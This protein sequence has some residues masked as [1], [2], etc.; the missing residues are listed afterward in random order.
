MLQTGTGDDL[1]A[2]RR[3]RDVGRILS[4]LLDPALENAHIE[5]CAVTAYI[6]RPLHHPRMFVVELTSPELSPTVSYP[7][8][9]SASKP[10]IR[11]TNSREPGDGERIG[12]VP[13]W[14][15]NRG[16]SSDRE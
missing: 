12:P 4:E 7:S 14:V 2:H 16:G 6:E 5:E 13:R 1:D 8:D 11:I 9:F 15:A 10:A 3:R